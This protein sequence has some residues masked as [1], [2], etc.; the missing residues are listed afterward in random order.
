M[1]GG[2]LGRKEGRERGW[3]KGRWGEG[4]ERREGAVN[5]IIL[6]QKE[7]WAVK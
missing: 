6:G 4:G 5:K 7:V 1:D 2:K 3:R